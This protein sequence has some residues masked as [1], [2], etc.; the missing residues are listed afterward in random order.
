LR[1]HAVKF[2]LVS[3][4]GFDFFQL[5]LRPLLLKNELSAVEFRLQLK[6]QPRFLAV[7]RASRSL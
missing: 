5:H 6:L 4:V 3:Q 1:R 7:S 2:L